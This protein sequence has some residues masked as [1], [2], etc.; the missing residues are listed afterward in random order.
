MV[1]ADRI[2]SRLGRLEADL[3]DLADKQD[4]SNEEYRDDR[5]LQAIVERRFETAIQACLDVASHIVASAGYREATN[6][7]ELFRILEEE[8]V[9]SPSVADDMVEMAGFR[10]VLAHEYADIDH[11]RVYDHLQDLDHFR[12]FAEEIT[13]FLGS[14]R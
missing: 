5:D 10:N 8:N 11:D 1:D 6:Y 2:R 12:V 7:G 14:D 4:A 9:L 3:H 13:A